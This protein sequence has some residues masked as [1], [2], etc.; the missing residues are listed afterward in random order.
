MLEI[1]GSEAVE[2]AGPKGS[3]GL[4]DAVHDREPSLDDSRS[5]LSSQEYGERNLTKR[6]LLGHD[7]TFRQE[8]MTS[9]AR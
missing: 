4:K 5:R 8:M 6:R 9:C 1:T 7:L 3:K 2:T